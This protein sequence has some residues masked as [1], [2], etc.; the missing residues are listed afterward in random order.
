M[1]F[2]PRATPSGDAAAAVAIA[3]GKGGVGK[4]L[5][6]HHLSHALAMAGRRVLLVDA[7]LASPMWTCSSG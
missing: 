5:A 6:R 3:S 2:I 7:D 1:S 4:D